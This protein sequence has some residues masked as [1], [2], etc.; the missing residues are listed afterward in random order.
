MECH[1]CGAPVIEGQKFCHECGESLAGV[2]DSTERLDM[3][4][5]SADN[6]EQDITF[7]LI[8]AEQAE[9][10]AIDEALERIGAGTFGLC[11]VCEKGIKAA[12]LKAIAHA[13]LCIAC[14]R[15]EEEGLL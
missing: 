8:E 14:K 12:R 1:A 13:R 4:D 6:Y 3:A 15:K 7:G 10:R 11:E 9:V 2:T 5:V